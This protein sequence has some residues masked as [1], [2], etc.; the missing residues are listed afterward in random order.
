MLVLAREA[1][2][3]S[4]SA[5]SAKVDASQSKVSKIED[6]SFVPSPEEIRVFANALDRAPAF[7]YR[8]GRATASAVSFYRKTNSLSLTAF[9]QCNARMNIKRL[10]EEDHMASR[11]NRA[12]LLPF[13]DIT[14]EGGPAGCARKIRQ[15]WGVQRGPIPNLTRLA[16]DAGCMVI[17]FDFG[18]K[19]IDGLS[20][21]AEGETPF[22]FLNKEFPFGRMRLTL[23]HEIGHL[24]M[25]RTPH[26]NV[27]EEAWAFASELLMP[28]AE[29]R[30]K[31]FPLTLEVLVALKIE[32]GV[33]MQALLKR[34]ENLRKISPRYA[35]YLWMQMS[36]LGYR[37]HEPYDE[38][39]P[40]EEPRSERRNGTPA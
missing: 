24:V 12:D 34:G 35:R 19:K 23:A 7:F 13:F 32:W 15:L 39:T 30:A 1:A 4:Q 6:G 16:E 3:L 40:R 28:E 27:E 22:V 36:K 5:L 10:A 9:K 18:T 11:G 20:L 2:G 25:H 14:K 26:E 33:S 8:A 37:T 38:E 31:F 29:I 21:R 17:H